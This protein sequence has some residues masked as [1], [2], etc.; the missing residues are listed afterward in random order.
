MSCFRGLNGSNDQ[1]FVQVCW[2]QG[3]LKVLLGLKVVYSGV[4]NKVLASLR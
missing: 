1:D 4:E 3:G 2:N